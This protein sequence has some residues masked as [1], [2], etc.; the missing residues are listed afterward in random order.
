[1]ILSKSNYPTSGLIDACKTISKLKSKGNNNK[2]KQQQ[3]IFTDLILGQTMS[4]CMW[5]IK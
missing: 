4:A 3:H 5:I 1:M 2:K